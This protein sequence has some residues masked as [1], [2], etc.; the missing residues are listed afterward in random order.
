MC[1]TAEEPGAFG[2]AEVAADRSGAV[3]RSQRLPAIAL[4]AGRAE[5]ESV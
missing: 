5:R 2:G 1:G 4:V 3:G